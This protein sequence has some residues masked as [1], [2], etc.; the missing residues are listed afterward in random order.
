MTLNNRNNATVASVRRSLASGEVRRLRQAA[1]LAARPLAQAYGF[2]SH[3]WLDWER[4]VRT[5]HSSTCL[6]IARA[7]RAL[8]K[9]A[10][11]GAG[12]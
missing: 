1:H 8:R 6:R 4:G 3:Q 2:D 12:T 5:P 10:A 11:A 9:L 7:I